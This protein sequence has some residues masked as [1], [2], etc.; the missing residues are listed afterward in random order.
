[1]SKLIPRPRV[2]YK[3]QKI[4]EYENIELIAEKKLKCVLEPKV[5]Y[6]FQEMSSYVLEPKI[7]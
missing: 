4:S 2:L 1:M 7:F 5:L 3:F 6:Q